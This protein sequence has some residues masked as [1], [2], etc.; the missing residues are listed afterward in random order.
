[1]DLGPQVVGL[2]VLLQLVIFMTK[3]KS[4]KEDLRLD[5]Y[6]LLKDCTRQTILF[7]PTRAK[8]RTKF[9]PQMQDFKL[10]LDLNC[11]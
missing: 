2:H 5:Y 8:L 4:L 6:L 3:Q 7:S 11:K 9:N 1:M 10:V